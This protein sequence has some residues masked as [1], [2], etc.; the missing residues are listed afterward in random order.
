MKSFDVNLHNKRLQINGI[1][2]SCNLESGKNIVE[3]S[4]HDIENT[5]N[6]KVSIS[7]T[8]HTALGWLGNLYTK[9]KNE[10]ANGVKQVKKQI[11]KQEN[12]PTFNLSLVNQDIYSNAQTWGSHVSCFTLS[13][14]LLHLTGFFLFCMILYSRDNRGV[15]FGGFVHLAIICFTPLCVS[16]TSTDK[17]KGLFLFLQLCGLYAALTEGF[18]AQLTSNSIY[19][20]CASAVCC[21]VAWYTKKTGCRLTLNILYYSI[22][23]LALFSILGLWTLRYV[24]ETDRDHTIDQISQNN[25][26]K[27]YHVVF[28]ITTFATTVLLFV[29]NRV[30][31]SS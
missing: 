12:S 2:G 16:L 28:D 23:L 4:A 1:F 18:Y 13:M 27:D 25:G 19:I 30:F 22:H 3:K 14:I 5:H 11:P 31:Q 24:Y 9:S 20:F 10:G 17:Y 6:D 21:Q 8:S 29:C 15:F 26:F 7:S